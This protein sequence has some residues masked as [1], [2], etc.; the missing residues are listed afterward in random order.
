MLSIQFSEDLNLKELDLVLIIEVQP[1]NCVLK[2]ITRGKHLY[3]RKTENIHYC[4]YILIHI[5][6]A[7]LVVSYVNFL[8]GVHLM[9]HQI[10]VFMHFM[11]CFILDFYSILTLCQHPLVFYSHAVVST[12]L[13]GKSY[14]LLFYMFR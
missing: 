5:Y 11:H 9:C 1:F 7:H 4:I 3:A 12:S 2:K 10:I 14:T 13:C 8:L 6:E